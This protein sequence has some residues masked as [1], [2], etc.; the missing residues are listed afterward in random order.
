MSTYQ[1]AETQEEMN[2]A[3]FIAQ[4]GDA[5]AEIADRWV[6]E[7]VIEGEDSS[8]MLVKRAAEHVRANL[9][10]EIAAL[11]EANL[12]EFDLANSNGTGFEEWLEDQS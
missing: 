9:V 10:L 3:A 11:L 7:I 5:A 6:S 2:R 4:A 12:T 8:V 1:L